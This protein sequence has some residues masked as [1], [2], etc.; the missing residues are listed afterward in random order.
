MINNDSKSTDTAH[1]KFR[2]IMSAG[3]EEL[4]Q[5]VLEPDLDFL[6]LLLQ[7]PKLDESHLLTLLKRRDLNEELITRIHRFQK[8][9]SSHRLTLALVKNPAISGALIRH[10][11]PHIRLFEL[12][13]LCKMPGVSPDQKLAAERIILQRLPTTPLGNKISLAKRG[14]TT[15]IGELLKEGHPQVFEA[16]LNSPYLNEAAI[17]QFLRGA[18]ASAETISQVA[19]HMRWKE[20]PNLKLAILKN[21]R[22][23]DIWFTLWLPKLNLQTIK[24]LQMNHRSHPAKKHLITTELN[25]RGG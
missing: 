11:L 16:C 22:T 9:K 17:F 24:Q 18:T 7:H 25:K 12:A 23:P 5:L 8:Q 6:S 13:D 19:R 4:F 1:V 21:R 20:R 3:H 10:L 14:T 15:I 2:Q